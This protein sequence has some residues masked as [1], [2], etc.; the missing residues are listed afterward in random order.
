MHAR[1]ARRDTQ[2]RDRE[3]RAAL[4]H[5]AVQRARL[6]LGRFGSGVAHV[7]LRTGGGRRFRRFVV[8]MSLG[9]ARVEELTA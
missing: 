2:R 4:E 9:Q 3:P 8:A 6:A 7:V 5:R 1:T